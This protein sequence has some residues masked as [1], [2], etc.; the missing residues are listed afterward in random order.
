[1]ALN[2]V[3]LIGNLTKD[4][5]VKQVGEA[6]LASFTLAVNRRFKS[7]NANQPATDYIPVAAWRQSADFA[8]KYFAKGKQVYVA[9]AI[10]TYSYEQDGKKLYGFRINAEEVGF[11]DTAKTEIPA[12]P[13]AKVPA[14]A[15]PGGFIPMESIGTGDDLPY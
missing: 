2:K 12:K 6:K 5:E 13:A 11:A 10:E 4:V 1:M 14:Y 9:G 7:K 8:E 15:T 3:I